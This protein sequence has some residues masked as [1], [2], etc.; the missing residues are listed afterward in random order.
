[1]SSPIK[2]IR[3]PRVVMRVELVDVW[4]L[5][6]SYTGIFIRLPG[7]EVL[8]HKQRVNRTPPPSSNHSLTAAMHADRL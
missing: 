5:G 3:D 6:P 7:F 4:F 8:P 1:M 2:F